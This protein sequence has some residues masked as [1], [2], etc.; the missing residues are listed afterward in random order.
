MKLQ[1]PPCPARQAGSVLVVTLLISM[2]IGITLAAFM[3]LSSAQHRAVIRSGVW[4]SCIPIAESGLEE[5]LT[6]VFL[7]S[8][9][10]ESQGWTKTTSGLTMSN[11]I[12]LAGTVYYKSRELNGGRFLA[13]I[14][15]GTTPTLTVQ[16]LL[17]KPLTTNDMLT[18]TIEVRT[19]GSSLFA[20]GLVARG[21]I[22]WNGGILSDSFDSQN[23]TLSTGGRYDPAK[24]NDN[25]SIGSVEGNVDVGSSGTI[26]GSV[27]T[28]PTG[29]IT[30]GPHAAVGSSAYIAGG[31]TGIQTGHSQNDLNISFPDA[32]VPFTS[33]YTI[34]G[35]G[36][37]VNVS[38]VSTNSTA[39]NSLVYPTTPPGPVTT[40]YP[41]SISYPSGTTY[42]VTTN[43][44]ATTG[45]V[46]GKTVTTY[47]TNFTF[48][49]FIWTATSYTTNYST[50]YYEHILDTGDY[51]LTGIA[52]A[53]V[54]VRGNARLWVD[55]SGS[56]AGG[57]AFTI[58]I[59]GTL[60]MWVRDSVSFSGNAAANTTGD[61]LRMRINGL[62]TCTDISFSGNAE[63]TGTIYAP[64]A[65]LRF[66]GG[67]M[68]RADFMGAAIVGS[69]Q[70]NG[71]FEFHYDENLG[72]AGPS[73]AFV[74]ASWV[75]L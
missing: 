17:P 10:L 22:N 28:G 38:S 50:N 61:A 14:Q 51:Y 35:G 43:V 45:K 7:N 31:S 67:G 8:T 42:P 18:R 75:E 46:K 1:P 54:L 27:G 21:T 12:A 20:R 74:I 47:T 3:D 40:N 49:Q 41:T 44:V 66:N 37:V 5:A 39:S 57:K 52:N 6:H 60:Q 34:P 56:E 2:I 11:S 19:V 63:F 36:N 25:G 48:T 30:T 71:H 62:P 73:S 33:G 55:G 65:H 58:S 70:L 4:N 53:N 16:G 26:Y 64:A 9:N 13:A 15:G 69:A 59:T 23:S 32:S 68:D 72:R 29:S 24:R